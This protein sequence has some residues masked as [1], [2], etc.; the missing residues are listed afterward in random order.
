MLPAVF[1]TVSHT[2]FFLL[3]F[4]FVSRKDFKGFGG[5]ILLID[6]VIL[7]LPCRGKST[8]HSHKL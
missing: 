3:L 5:G 8:H 7:N 4:Y 1:N 2:Y 6:A